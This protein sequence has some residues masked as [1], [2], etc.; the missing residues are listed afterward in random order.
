MTP[1][2]RIRKIHRMFYPQMSPIN[3]DNNGSSRF[4][5]KETGFEFGKT[6]R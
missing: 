5:E 4:L 6:A 1:A 3:A 2:S